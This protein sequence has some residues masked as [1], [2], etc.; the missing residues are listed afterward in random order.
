MHSTKIYLL[1]ISW[2]TIGLLT[3]RQ[4]NINV[5]HMKWIKTNCINKS[6][7]VDGLPKDDDDSQTHKSFSISAASFCFNK[8]SS[9]YPLI[10][11]S[12]FSHDVNFTLFINLMIFTFSSSEDNFIENQYSSL[13]W[14]FRFETVFNIIQFLPSQFRFLQKSTCALSVSLSLQFPRQIMCLFKN[15]KLVLVHELIHFNDCKMC[16]RFLVGERFFFI[17]CTS[18]NAHKICSLVPCFTFFFFLASP[19]FFLFSIVNSV[20][21]FFVHLNSL[22][23]NSIWILFRSRTMQLFPHSFVE[24]LCMA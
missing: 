17:F 8:C 3:I 13:H 20:S 18:R 16:K 4:F 14:S 22:Q 5:C 23:R 2:K 1:F 12:L 19:Y 24:C 11:D 7:N 10:V 9:E 6:T 21:L 15:E